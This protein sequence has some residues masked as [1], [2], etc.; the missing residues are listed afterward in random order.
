M[1]TNDTSSFRARL[2]EYG[3]SKFRDP[4]TESTRDRQKSLMLTSF[5][6][7]ALSSA[8]VSITGISIGGGVTG[9]I[10]SLDVV[11]TVSGVISIYFLAA[12]ILCILQDLNM[13]TYRT[14]LPVEDMQDM[15]A[16]KVQANLARA[17]AN[18]ERLHA[19]VNAPSMLLW[20][21]IEAIKQKYAGDDDNPQLMQEQAPIFEKLKLIGERATELTKNELNPFNSELKI[22]EEQ[23]KR[24]R[25]IQSASNRLSLARLVI[26][27]AFPIG[28][29]LFAIW[30]SVL[31]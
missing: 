8:A 20:K 14:L 22:F 1:T 6:A 28:L 31:K 21:E 16:K 25:K 18:S 12:Y 3:T 11:K 30:M 19:E 4:L 29:A 17:T 27:I 13:H 10:Q 7:V 26:E 15:L 24:A 2:S 23:M 9:T 5:I